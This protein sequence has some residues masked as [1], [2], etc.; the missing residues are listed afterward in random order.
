V[1]WLGEEI[2]FDGFEGLFGED[3]YCVDD[4]VKERLWEE[5]N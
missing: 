2:L 1:R 3:V 5:V 4:V